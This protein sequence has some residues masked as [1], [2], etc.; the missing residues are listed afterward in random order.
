MQLRNTRLKIVDYNRNI[1][2]LT[3]LFEKRLI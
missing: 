2:I 1:Q 3:T